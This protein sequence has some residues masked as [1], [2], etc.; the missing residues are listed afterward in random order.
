M[1]Q[2]YNKSTQIKRIDQE[3]YHEM[4]QQTREYLKSILLS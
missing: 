4:W 3:L 2:Q 1:I